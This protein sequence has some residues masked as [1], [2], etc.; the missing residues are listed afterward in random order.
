MFHVPLEAESGVWTPR[1]RA[2]CDGTLMRS[3]ARFVWL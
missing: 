1:I 2:A 3:G